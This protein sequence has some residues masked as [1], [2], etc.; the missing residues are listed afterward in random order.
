MYA[1]LLLSIIV[2]AHI[3]MLTCLELVYYSLLFEI[4]YYILYLDSNYNNEHLLC[5]ICVFI[6]NNYM[7]KVRGS[8]FYNKKTSNITHLEWI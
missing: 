8:L 3:N 6:I 1:L 5:Y 7:V 4:T 2:L